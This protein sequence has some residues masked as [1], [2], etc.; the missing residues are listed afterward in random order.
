MTGKEKLNELGARL[1]EARIERN[2]MQ[3]MFA[4][5]LGVSRPTLS[6]LEAGD[7]G[8]SIGVWVKVLQ[9][10][11]RVDDLDHLLASRDDLFT[12]YDRTTRP[13]RLRASRKRT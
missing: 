6:R 10:L 12:Q 5:R 13:R 8:V 9:L 4:D 1:R 3:Q 11:D 2:E 7:P